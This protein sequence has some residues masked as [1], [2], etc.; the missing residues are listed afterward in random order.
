MMVFF[1]II[2][3]RGWK[4]AN[5]LQENGDVYHYLPLIGQ[6]PH[7]TGS[8]LGVDGECQYLG[9]D[10]LQIIWS[11][12]DGLLPLPPQNLKIKSFFPHH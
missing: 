1:P 12:G 11:F 7:A 5:D 8:E 9:F 3:S 2:I 6:Q 4:K 10:E